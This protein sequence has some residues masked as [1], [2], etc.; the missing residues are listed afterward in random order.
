MTYLLARLLAALP[1]AVLVA[2]AALAG[3][4]GGARYGAPDAVMTAVDGAFAR[5]GAAAR[6]LRGGEETPP[7]DGETAVEAG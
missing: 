6:S 5:A 2:I 3:W 4:Y 1:R 7:H